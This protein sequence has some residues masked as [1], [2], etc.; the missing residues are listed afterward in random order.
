M[1]PERI[2]RVSSTGQ[3][4]SHKHQQWETAEDGSAHCSSSSDTCCA[5][6]AGGHN[7][8]QAAAVAIYSGALVAIKCRS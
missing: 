2:R 7:S 1:K 4:A 6:A 3:A 8:I 5:C